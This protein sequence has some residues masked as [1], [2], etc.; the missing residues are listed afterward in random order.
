ML[1]TLASNGDVLVTVKFSVFVLELNVQVT[2]A[3]ARLPVEFPTI[4]AV[5]AL[6]VMV[7]PNNI[8]S[9]KPNIVPE[10][11]LFII[12][13]SGLFL[14]FSILGDPVL[15]NI[16]SKRRIRESFRLSIRTLNLVVT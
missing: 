4:V 11:T 9:A 8:L 14:D 15:V 2:V 10:T 16:G 1:V 6:V 5:A 13:S 12:Y 3:V 7:R